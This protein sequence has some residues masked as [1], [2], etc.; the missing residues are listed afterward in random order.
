MN[1]VGIDVSKGRSTVAVM[2]PLGEVVQKPREVIHS[3]IELERLA[4]QII[5]LGENTRV[6]MEATGRYH[7]PVAAALHEQG[8]YVTI[9]NPILIKQ[10]GGGSVRKVKTDKKDALKIAKYGLDNWN[11]LRE[12]TPTD[13][14]RQQLKLFSR[15]YN[16][17]MKISVMLKNN[18]IALLD[19][20]FSGANELFDSQTRAD[21]HQKWVDFV[22]AFWHCDCIARIN[23]QAFT[24]RYQKWCKRKG[25]HFSKTKAEDVYYSSAGHFP[26][27][28]RN[29][30]TKLLITSAANA[31]TDNQKVLMTIKAEVLRLAELMPEHDVVLEMYG[32]GDIT[33]AQLMAE[34][35]DVRRFENRG[36]IVAFAGIDPE[37]SESGKTKSESN[38]TTKRGSPHLR[39]TLFQI[40]KTHLIRSPVNEPVYLFLDKKRRQGKPYFVYMTAAANKFLRIYHAKVKEHL[41]NLD[42]QP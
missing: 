8:I 22:T 31:L 32:V 14:L 36:S 34:L 1:S 4:Y 26:T 21:G 37:V 42:A 40:A 27:L 9:L 20:T 2:R 28:P 24:E 6:V 7:E 35:G 13:A 12:Y 39:K 29:S 19:K 5:E 15:Q 17:Y 33:A 41:N 38:S 30:N 10:S 3:T 16:L 23:Q 11:G 25:Y 18:L